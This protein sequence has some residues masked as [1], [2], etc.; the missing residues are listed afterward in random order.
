MAP[1]VG[2]TRGPPASS[3]RCARPLLTAAGHAGRRQW[4]MLLPASPLLGSRSAK[5]WDGLDSPL[6][7]HSIWPPTLLSAGSSHTPLHCPSSVVPPPSILPER[8]APSGTSRRSV[9]EPEEHISPLPPRGRVSVDTP[10]PSSCWRGLSHMSVRGTFSLGNNKSNRVFP[11]CPMSKG[12][13]E[14][15]VDQAEYLAYISSSI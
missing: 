11:S 9:L 12:G 10:P 1:R 3:P 2:T 7:G 13:H 4:L 14:R 6:G 5:V 15:Q 8:S